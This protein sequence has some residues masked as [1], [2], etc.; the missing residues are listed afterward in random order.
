MSA[1]YQSFI[2]EDAEEQVAFAFP[3]GQK[4]LAGY[5]VNGV[6]VGKRSFYEEGIL[7]VETPLRDG[8]IHGNCYGWYPSGDLMS[9]VPYEQ[10]LPH[11][12]ATLW[13][14]NGEMLDSYTMDNG[15]GIRLDWQYV[16]NDEGGFIYLHRVDYLQNGFRHGV[17]WVINPDQRTIAIENYYYDDIPHGIERVWDDQGRLEPEYPKYY[18]RGQNLFGEQHE[19][20]L[21]Q[22]EYVAVSNGDLTLPPYREE[23]NDPVRDFP[24]EV[25][26]HLWR[27]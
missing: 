24:P 23:E 25:A 17:A 18:I 3:N 13:A 26:Q 22:E 12:T 10:G 14:P 4:A 21:S 9:I 5:F 8:K 16:P 1:T 2:P 11:G 27:N 7:S 15:T 6:S 20:E 19:Q